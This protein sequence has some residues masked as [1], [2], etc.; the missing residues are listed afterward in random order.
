MHNEKLQKHQGRILQ[1]LQTSFRNKAIRNLSS[2]QL[3]PIETEVLALGL[4]F[5]LT[6]L[7]SILLHNFIQLSLDSGSAQVQT[8]FAVCRRFAMVRIS[9]NDP[10]WK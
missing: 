10:G 9:D 7:A 2:Q 4:N 5:V 8:L 3:S 6:P 1:E